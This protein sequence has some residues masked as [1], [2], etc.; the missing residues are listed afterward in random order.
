MMF[1]FDASVIY[2]THT[3]EMF[4]FQGINWPYV[5]VG[6][7]VK[8]SHVELE[9][10]FPYVHHYWV[11]GQQYKSVIVNHIALRNWQQIYPFYD[12]N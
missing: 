12:C 6:V 9:A 8:A 7:F 2:L 10:L 5:A 3:C 1:C 11:N 4:P